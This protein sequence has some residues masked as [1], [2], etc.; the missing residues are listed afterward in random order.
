MNELL[1]LIASGAIGAAL[2]ML[3]GFPVLKRYID[4]KKPR[5]AKE[6]V[7]ALTHLVDVLKENDTDEAVR[8]QNELNL[9]LAKLRDMS[10]AL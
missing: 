6:A 9:Q 8:R 3:F 1:A 4:N 7:K 5:A 2:A 10:S